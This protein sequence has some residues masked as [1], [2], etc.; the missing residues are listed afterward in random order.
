MRTRRLL[1]GYGL[2]LLFGMHGAFAAPATDTVVVCYSGGSV[3]QA[4]ANAAMGAMLRVVERV[5]QWPSGHFVSAFTVST[6]ECRGLL[7]ARKPGFAIMPLG[8]YL[9]RRRSD[10][11]IPLVQPRID[12]RLAERYRLVVRKGTFASLAAVKGHTVGG[13][14][15]DDL[16]FL[17]RIVF[18]GQVDAS[19]FLLRPSNQGIRALRSLDRGEL[20]A[21]LLNEQQ[22]NGLGALGLAS[23][24]D[25]VFTSQEIPLLGLAAD[26]V[27]STAEE[28]SRFAKSLE[29]M[30][31]DAEGKKLCDLFGISA[32]VPVNAKAYDAAVQLWEKGG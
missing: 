2:A 11:W 21:V 5:G 24:L 16:E 8:V 12:G 3:S 23:P 29:T 9:D 19:S 30:C 22:Y 14:V 28:R 13:T 4:D 6:P 15:L 7:S 25:V 20:D 26:G 31:N 27:K 1:I 10:H 17:S 32:F 18:A